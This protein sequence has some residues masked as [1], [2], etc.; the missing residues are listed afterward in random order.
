MDIG[1]RAREKV[2]GRGA[3]RDVVVVTRN[4]LF[5]VDGGTSGGLENAILLT[6]LI[7]HRGK[8]L[9]VDLGRQ[10]VKRGYFVGAGQPGLLLRKG[11]R[12]QS[13]ACAEEQLFQSVATTHH[14]ATSGPRSRFLADVLDVHVSAFTLAAHERLARRNGNRASLLGEAGRESKSHA[15]RLDKD[16]E[17]ECGWR[18][19]VSLG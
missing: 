5:H 15:E 12:I 6:R 19:L 7:A 4:G 13:D 9:H 3:G 14:H 16:A 1:G 11:R 2:R 17:R 10:C 18:V 8:V